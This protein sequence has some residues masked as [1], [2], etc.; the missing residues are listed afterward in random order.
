[1]TS[2]ITVAVEENLKN[3]ESQAAIQTVLTGHHRSEKNKSRDIY[4]HPAETLAFFGLKPNMTVVE[5]WPGS[6]WYTEI[7]APF[8]RQNGTLYT[9][10]FS[11]NM[12]GRFYRNALNDFHQ[13]IASNP[14][15]YG[16]VQLTSLLPPHEIDIA[17]AGS[18]DLVLT[19]RNVHNWMLKGEELN[20]LKSIYRALKPGGILGLVEHRENSET[21]HDAK[22]RKG[23]VL[24][25]YV[26]FM[27]EKAG[28]SLLD[29]SEINSNPN[30]TKYHPKGVWTLPPTLKLGEK[31]KE[32][33]L[34]IG[35]SDRM[36]LKFLKPNK[37]SDNR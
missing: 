36:T 20:V 12:K 9:A 22:A 5:I 8:L 28:F 13:K 29:K 16:K 15:I 19:F 21:E 26:I 14:E 2:Q 31:D 11:P 23:Y 18:A 35:E 7:L 1:M 37:V 33:Y 25:K 24:Q 32:K 34:A 3:D 6:G 17:P 30:D 10:H 4:R 27:A